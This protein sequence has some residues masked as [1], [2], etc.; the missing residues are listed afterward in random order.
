M[1]NSLEERLQAVEDRLAIVDLVSRY[2]PAADSGDSDTI[3]DLWA[4]DGT[5]TFDQTTLEGDGVAGLVN[6]DTHQAF[7]SNG[8]AHFLSSPRIDLSGATAIAVNHSIVLEKQG[9]SWVAVRVS[10]NRWD[11]VKDNG[12]WKVKHRTAQLLNGEE[13]SRLLFRQAER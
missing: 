6:L 11:L 10:A 4:T 8:C 3:G 7:M 1:T 13:R 12:A 9:D 5:Y 2:G